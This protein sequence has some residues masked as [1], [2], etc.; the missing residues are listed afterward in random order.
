MDGVVDR[1]ACRDRATGRVDV[2]ID[3]FAAVFRVEVEHLSHQA[4]GDAVI[5]FGAKKQDPFHPE[6]GVDVDP[7]LHLAAGNAA[8]QHPVNQA[9]LHSLIGSQVAHPVGIL[10]Q[11][12]RRTPGVGGEDFKHGL[13]VVQHFLGTDLDI[14]CLPLGAAAGLMQNDRGMGEGCPLPLG[15]GRENH[16]SGSHGLADADGVHRRL[17]IAEGVADGEGFGLEADGITRIPAGSRGVDIEVNGLLGVI[18][19]QIKKLSDDQLGDIDPHLTL[20]IVVGKQ[21]ESQIND[22]FLQ[23]Q[24]RKIW[25]GSPHHGAIAV[26]GG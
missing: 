26:I 10:A 5:D 6:A 25:R 15:A 19:L 4:V 13:L 2:Q 3:R 14:R 8:A 22:P 7:A 16:R 20:G 17:H 12:L 11:L 9:V 18:E 1:E 24:G 23:Q 21:G